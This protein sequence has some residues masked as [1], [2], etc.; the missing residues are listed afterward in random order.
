LEVK[1]LESQKLTAQELAVL[2]SSVELTQVRYG[3]I[4]LS[5]TRANSF[6]HLARSVLSDTLLG[7]SLSF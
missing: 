4:A 2:P 3:T 5:L 6:P 7:A 1:E